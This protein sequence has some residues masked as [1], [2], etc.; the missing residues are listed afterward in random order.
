LAD[1]LDRRSDPEENADRISQSAAYHHRE[2]SRVPEDDKLVDG[3]INDVKRCRYL[4]DYN[5]ATNATMHD[6][7][8]VRGCHTLSSHDNLEWL[9]G[10]GS[11]FGM[12]YVD[13]PAQ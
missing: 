5:A 2:C 8:D 6:G 3:G 7:A 1:A 10:Y 12:L 9:S 4:V 13:F 11:L